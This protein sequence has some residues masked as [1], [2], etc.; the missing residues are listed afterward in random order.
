MDIDFS[1]TAIAHFLKREKRFFVYVDRNN[2][3][4][5]ST[6]NCSVAYCP[7]VG[8]MT[9]L[10]LQGAQCVFSK[11]EGKLLWKWEIVSIDNVLIG[12]NT[13]NPNYLVEKNLYK[14]FP[15]E[16]F[17]KE[18]SFDNYRCDFASKTK[19]IEVKNVH[20][21]VNDSAYFPDTLTSRGA[22]QMLDLAQLSSSGY[23]CYVIYVIQRSD[24]QKVS[25]AQWIDQLYSKNA[26]I[27]KNSGVKFLG[28]NCQLNQEGISLLSQIEVF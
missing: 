4:F 6:N 26:D 18:V 22:R 25:N 21:K 5:I 3:N 9:D 27:A 28:F 12:V 14:I 13:Q 8:K 7:N 2:K 10:L 15:N 20:W 24:C 1:E 23:D 17:K 19:I 11:Y 16:N